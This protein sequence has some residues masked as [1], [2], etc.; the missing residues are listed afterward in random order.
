MGVG[1]PVSGDASLL[2]SRALKPKT[3]ALVVLVVGSA[4]ILRELFPK[5][6]VVASPPRIRTVHDTVATVDTVWLRRAAQPSKPDTV[7]LERVSVTP[8][9]T[10][11]VAP[12]LVGI[13]GLVVAPWVGD[14]TV[15][16]GF[17][18]EPVDT[19]YTVSQWQAQFYTM[20]PVRAVTLLNGTPQIGFGPPPKPPCGRGCVAKHVTY[21]AIFGAALWEVFR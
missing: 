7:Y 6:E 17:R 19:G 8:P 9:E 16:Q 13:T 3:W 10:V 4:V 18:L 5:R 15:V 1:S 14:S 12:S 20:G 11:K 2:A 21:G